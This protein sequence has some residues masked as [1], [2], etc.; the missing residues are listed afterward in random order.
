MLKFAPPNP[1]L[2]SSY[3]NYEGPTIKIDESAAQ[4]SN[5]ASAGIGMFNDLSSS[6]SI[7][8]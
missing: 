4:L 3:A 5:T 6:D 8:L 1:T 7:Y 2:S